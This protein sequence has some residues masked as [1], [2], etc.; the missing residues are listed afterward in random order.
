M[1]VTNILRNKRIWCAVL[2]AL[3]FGLAFNCTR[4][5]GFWF[6]RSNWAQ[7]A[8]IGSF[9]L[10]SELDASNPTDL[11]DVG[12]LGLVRL[13]P[14]WTH[15]GK[16]IVFSAVSDPG[17]TQFPVYSLHV[18]ASDGSS[19]QT[20]SELS[21]ENARDHSPIISSDGSRVLYSSYNYVDE[22]KQYFEITISALD[23]SNQ[24]TLTHEVG[25]DVPSAWLR[26]DTRIAFTR[27]ATD[28]CG[29]HNPS[30]EGLYTMRPDGSD[31]RRVP[32]GIGEGFSEEVNLARPLWWSPDER[33][34]AFFV[35]ETFP[36]RHPSTNIRPY[37][38]TS[39]V[40]VD[41]HDSKLTRLVT[42]DAR[43]RGFGLE[44]SSFVG[45]IVWSPDGARITFLRRLDQQDPSDLL[46]LYS[47]NRDGSDLREVVGPDADYARLGGRKLSWSP[48]Y[49]G[50]QVMFSPSDPLYLVHVDGSDYRLA[51]SLLAQ[52]GRP[53]V[54]TSWSPDGSRVAVVGSYGFDPTGVVVLYTAAPDGSDVRIL[55][56]RKNRAGDAELEAV[57][58]EQRRSAVVSSRST[59]VA[60]CSAGLVVPDPES[61]PG[62]VRDCEALV[63]LMDGLAVSRLNWD[64]DTPIAEW[65]GV[66]LNASLLE[67]NGSE[68]DEPSSPL[69]VRG[70]T[71]PERGIIGRLPLAVTELTGLW[72]LDLSNSHLSGPIPPELGHLVDL[73]VLKI[74]GY[75]D[76]P[77]PPELGQLED[78]R[79]LELHGYQDSPIPPE[80][81]QLAKLEE[82]T[83][84]G[85]RSGPIPPDLGN[86]T[87][88]HRLVLNGGRGGP[89]PPDLGNLA[90][91]KTLD[92]RGSGLSGPI[93]P[94]LDNLRSLET[95]DLGS[96]HNLS[97]CIPLALYHQLANLDVPEGVT[98][99][100][101]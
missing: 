41:V 51:D 67:E 59:D 2:V 88:L 32:P 84:I 10:E 76:G 42:G 97:G 101:E 22:Q 48:N 100:D 54:D 71:L 75:L 7:C 73:R 8:F 92:L 6:D 57:G 16:H 21:D 36:E 53:W 68:S 96:N 29:A 60:S 64:A 69:R 15:D 47:I 61:K 99:C 66:S 46:K 90:A 19:L 13:S 26:N 56:R 89:I 50:Q 1:N 81:G 37:Y 20:L 5:V 86:L 83:L 14:R 74:R 17:G 79:E 78:L 4:I 23:G 9:D 11:H 18:I 77:I 95:L 30:D 91:L 35:T 31:L 28:S 3:I 45:P 65:E 34:V 62:L 72:S 27:N 55:A 40:T 24:Q 33:T 52:T 39:L 87:S 38:R 49:D 58:P 70:L 44:A 12:I 80:L 93:P 85:S 94:E 43:N 25:V 63:E 82:L 98:V